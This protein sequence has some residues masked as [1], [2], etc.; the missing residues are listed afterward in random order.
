[1]GIE[2]ERV[3]SGY[4]SEAE[5]EPEMGDFKEYHDR[6]GSETIIKPSGHRVERLLRNPFLHAVINLIT[7]DGYDVTVPQFCV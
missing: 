7:G 4:F 1:M 6:S 5:N 3:P 2:G